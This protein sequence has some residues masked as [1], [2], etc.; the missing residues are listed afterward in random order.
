MVSIADGACFPCLDAGVGGGEMS[1]GAGFPAQPR[2]ARIFGA[3]FVLL[4]RSV[5]ILIIFGKQ[6]QTLLLSPP[7]N[8]AFC[9][10]FCTCD[11]GVVCLGTLRVVFFFFCF[12]FEFFLIGGNKVS[13]LLERDA[14]MRLARWMV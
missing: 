8:G 2:A 3:G 11:V 14:Q 13:E 4:R 9:V 6:N 12:C 1:P 7:P 5:F 10:D